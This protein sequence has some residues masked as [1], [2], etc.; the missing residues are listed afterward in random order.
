MRKSYFVAALTLLAPMG[1]AAQVPPG[2][3]A[4]QKPGEKITVIGEQPKQVCERWVPTGSIKA[5]KVCR[6][7]SDWDVIQQDSL[8]E[9]Q[10]LEDRQQ[11][12]RR[13]REA[14]EMMR[15]GMTAN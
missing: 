15:D 7:Q 13:M 6:S 1:V 9:L 10:R 2:N 5:Q 14:R 3:G 4:P 11:F 12:S 8:T